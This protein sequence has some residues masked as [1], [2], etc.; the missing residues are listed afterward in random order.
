MMLR[1]EVEFP[2]AVGAAGVSDDQ[3]AQELDQLHVPTATNVRRP[4]ALNR[5]PVLSANDQAGVQ[6][7]RPRDTSARRGGAN[8]A[9]TSPTGHA[10]AD[11]CATPRR[12]LGMAGIGARA[13]ANAGRETS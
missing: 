7:G 2:G 9:S 6:H 3:F 4:A 13:R 5:T 10:R 8:I 11:C 1:A 12:R